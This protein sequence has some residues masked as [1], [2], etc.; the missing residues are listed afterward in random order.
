MAGWRALGRFIGTQAARAATGVPLPWP[1]SMIEK[2][3]LVWR[4]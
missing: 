4:A 3:P 1:W 2:L